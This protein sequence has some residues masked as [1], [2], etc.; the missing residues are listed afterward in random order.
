MLE[1]HAAIRTHEG[2]LCLAESLNERSM[3]EFLAPAKSDCH[4]DEKAQVNCVFLVLKTLVISAW[5][6]FSGMKSIHKWS[7]S[8][9]SIIMWVE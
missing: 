6:G 9:R 3:L 2:K 5:K 1:G 7:I 4:L 8:N